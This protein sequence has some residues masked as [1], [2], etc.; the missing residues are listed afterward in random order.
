MNTKCYLKCMGYPELRG[1]DGLPVKLKVRKHLA[2][3]VYLA[4]DVRAA[5][6]RE[7]LVELLWGGVAFEK[8][9]HS[10]SMALSVLRGV[11]GSEALLSTVSNVR[12]AKGAVTLDLEL[13]QRGQA[14][15]DETRP[16][17]DVESF[18]T[19]FEIVD[20]P[21]FQH[22]RDRHHANFLPAIRAGLLSLVDHARRSGDMSRVMQLADRL[23]A[24]DDLAEEGIR[25]KM[26]AFAMQGDR[27][28]ALRTFAN[29]K[30]RL[31]VEISAT[32]SDILE[33]MATRLRRRGAE[34][35][36]APA[37]PSVQTEHWSGRRFI[38]RAAQYRVLTEAWESATQLNTRHVLLT[39]ETGIGK[40]TLAMRFATSAALEGAAVARVQCFEL[41]QRIPF[42]MISSLVTSLLDQP[43]VVGTA[44]ESLAEVARIIPKIRDRFR[45]LPL[46][47]QTEGEAARLLFAEGCFAIFESIM[48]EQ[49]LILIVDDYPRSDEASL[50]VL[51]MLLRRVTH[52]R[53][54][55]VL[56]GRPHEAGEPAQAARI[57]RGIEYLPINRVEIPPLSEDE[58][59]HMLAA[60]LESTGKGPRP[61][62]RRAILRTAAGNPMALELLAQDWSVH[63][64][65]ALAVSLPAMRSDMPT[66]AFEAVGYDRLIDRMLPALS[67][68]TRAALY[69]AAILGPRLNDIESF[70]IVDLTPAQALAATSELVT[71]RVLRD[72]GA[73]LEFTNELIRARLYL[74][75]PS[76]ARVR[77]HDRVVD[78]LLVALGEGNGIPGLEISWHCMR[79]RRREEAAPFLMR[80]A[81]EAILHGAPD[82][83]ARALASALGQLKGR[84]KVEATLLLAESYQEMG[85]LRASLE[86]LCDMGASGQSDANLIELADT[87]RMDCE[88]QIGVASVQHLVSMVSRLI[89]KACTDSTLTS[90]VRAASAAASLAG[91]LLQPELLSAARDACDRISVKELSSYESGRIELAKAITSYHFRQNEKGLQEALVAA[92][93]L[94]AVGAMDTTFVQIQ[95]GL[96]AIACANGAYA[97]GIAPLE[98]AYATAS[99][100]DN[101]AL[102]C[103]AASNLALCFYRV[104]V[105]ESHL[106]WALTAW[107][108]CR[109]DGR[110]GSYDRL[111]SSAQCSLA[112]LGLGETKR[113]ITAREWLRECTT[114]ARLDWVRQA[115]WLYEADI[116]WLLGE[117]PRALSAVNQALEISREALS[118]GFVGRIARWRTVQSLRG[119]GTE[120][121]LRFL[122]TWYNQIDRLDAFD[123]AEVLCSLAQLE[124]I[125]PA[126][127]SDVSVQARTALGRLPMA[128][129]K[130]IRALGLRLPD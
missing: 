29:W 119:G 118:L 55:M 113:A 15:G 37:S 130:Q 72:A 125:V 3:L 114:D 35:S 25:A 51:H 75:I 58:S 65:A 99:R 66:T 33:A 101:P 80:G 28:S 110:P 89:D 100:L 47:R 31:A 18:L 57:R 17:L 107:D 22:W 26:E 93:L 40:S 81:R 96:G 44:P 30:A 85:E 5:H 90:R 42:G 61:P 1:P 87:L 16:P 67:P 19:E 13:L 122:H 9:R 21:A 106:K 95:T 27:I 103:T 50:S 38:G 98:L 20:A 11:L 24:L 74:K 105:S 46:P 48:D 91:H 34:I 53:L 63:G 71:R 116:A 60:V 109:M 8:G 45:N 78:R 2:L 82:E 36:P 69:L 128:C 76:A 86:C 56:A 126:G 97:D 12:L 79:A 83:A 77:L 84:P 108:R 123:Q 41:E 54:M 112:Y 43:G 111:H 104:G 7:A 121:P 10:L 124:P 39:G 127:G 62:V 49:P 92:R 32:P 23:L 129:S 117:K 102:M 52:E 115:A 68:R 4:V 120:S 6:R 88:R 73:G 70:S 59:E 94:Q 14:L 64:D